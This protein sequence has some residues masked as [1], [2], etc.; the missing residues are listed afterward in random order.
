MAKRVF[1]I[2]LSVK[3]IEKLKKEL[4]Y[5]RD[6]ELP[7]K[8]REVVTRLANLGIPIIEEKISEASYEYDSKGI[9]TGSNT[10]HRTYVDVKS[11]QDTAVAKLI[12]EGKEILFIEFGSGIS[13][14]YPVGV[15]GTG[16]PMGEE[17]GYLIGTYGMGNGA[18]QVWGYYSEG[19]ELV[20]TRGTK[21]TMPMYHADQAIILMARDI[22]KEV[23][24]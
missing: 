19:G 16:H 24:S 5:Y 11:F 15:G 21:A 4:L 13:A 1:N 7:D 8:M 18:K 20:L 3:D 23:F 9:Q 6:V 17:F 14:N 10:E 2:G 12:C 22:I